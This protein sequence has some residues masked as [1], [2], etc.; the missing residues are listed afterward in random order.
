[1]ESAPNW[2]AVGCNSATVQYMQAKGDRRDHDILK[3]QEDAPGGFSER[4]PVVGGVDHLKRENFR[5]EWMA[6][7]VRFSSG[8]AYVRWSWSSAGSP[9]MVSTKSQ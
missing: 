3:S 1:V 4:L 6:R 2:R 9:S 7:Y 8:V 5:R